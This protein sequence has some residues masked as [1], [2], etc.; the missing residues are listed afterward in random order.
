VIGDVVVKNLASAM[1][2][3]KE[4]VQNPQPDGWYGEEVGRDNLIQMIL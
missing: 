2:Q 3:D 4:Y 1:L